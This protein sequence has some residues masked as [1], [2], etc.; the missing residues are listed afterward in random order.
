MPAIGAT[1]IVWIVILIVLGIVAQPLSRRDVSDMLRKVLDGSMDW[2]YG[3]TSP[4]SLRHDALLE[5]VLLE[6][7]LLEQRQYRVGAVDR[8]IFNE[9]GL[10]EV[11]VFGNA[12]A[13][14]AMAGRG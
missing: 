3:T 9:N 5:H 8:Y 14:G 4:R 12:G 6:C 1:V 2:T 10:Q 13:S 11:R 7:L